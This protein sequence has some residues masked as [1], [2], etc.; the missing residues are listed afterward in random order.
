MFPDGA[1]R[2]EKPANEE[3]RN[4]VLS[5]VAASVKDVLAQSGGNAMLP[6]R[7]S[8]PGIVSTHMYRGECY[9][10]MYTREVG[11]ACTSGLPTPLLVRVCK[12]FEHLGLYTG[13]TYGPM[14]TKE[15]CVSYHKRGVSLLESGASI[16][17]Q[18]RQIS[19]PRSIIVLSSERRTRFPKYNRLLLS[20]V[21]TSTLA[22]NA[23]IAKLLTNQ[24]LL[25]FVHFSLDSTIKAFYNFHLFSKIDPPKAIDICTYKLIDRER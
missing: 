16:N 5:S 25:S 14:N 13:I 17:T 10:L 8:G 22:Y 6:C 9:V 19:T 4:N 21:E 15:V 7:F 23:G 18:A 1:V 12:S 2:S 20:L 11:L 3:N 24:L